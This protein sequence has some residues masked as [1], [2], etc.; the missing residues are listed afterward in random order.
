MGILLDSKTI[1][2]IFNWFASYVLSFSNEDEY[3]QQNINVK[4]E[5]TKRVCNEI[6]NIGTHL[7]LNEQELALAEIIGLLHDVGRF[8]QFARYKTFRDHTTEDHAKLGIKIL[9]SHGVLNR[10][11]DKTKE[12][13]ICA[14]RFHNRPSLPKNETGSRMFFIKLLRDADKLDIWKVVTDYYLKPNDKKNG[15]LTLDMPDTPGFSDEVYQNI[16]NRSIV[17]MRHVNNINDLKLLQT[18]WIFD[19]NFAPTFNIIHDR[20]YL[21]KMHDVLPDTIKT[22]EI[23]ELINS[24]LD[25]YLNPEITHSQNDVV[26]P[27]VHDI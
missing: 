5:H 11:E 16:M 9:Q 17:D 23:F 21:E 10:L 7:G 8:E 14:I 4:E 18:G 20:H 1:E 26:H 19:I 12:L 15:A 3:I 27:P 24:F 6:I 13:I 22:K 25:N 2:E